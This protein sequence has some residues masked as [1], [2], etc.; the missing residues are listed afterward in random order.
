MEPEGSLP[1]S[2]VPATCSYPEPDWSSPYPHIPL[3]ED[4][5]LILTYHLH[6]CLPVVSFPQV[7]PPKPCII[8]SSPPYVLPAPPIS[9]FLSLSTEQ[10]W[11]SS[12]DH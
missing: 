10:Y 5:I 1:H 12:T 3:P 2:Q 4:P 11:V 6:L 7:S 9:F 8:L